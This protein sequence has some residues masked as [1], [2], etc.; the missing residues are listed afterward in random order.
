MALKV[1]MGDILYLNQLDYNVNNIDSL[2][3]TMTRKDELNL[4]LES[5]YFGF[6]AMT[7]RPDQRL[8]EL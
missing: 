4:A 1:N 6:R 3:L 5:M 8:G 7:Y 2:Y